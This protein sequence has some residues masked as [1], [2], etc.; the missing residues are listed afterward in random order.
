MV[1]SVPLVNDILGKNERD[2]V[3]AMLE[4]YDVF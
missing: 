3:V 1:V 4:T 2:L